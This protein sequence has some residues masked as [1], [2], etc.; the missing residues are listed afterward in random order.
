MELMIAPSGQALLKVHP[1]AEILCYLCFSRRKDNAEF[2]LAGSL[3]TIAAE[4]EAAVRNP[5]RKA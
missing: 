2:G 5:R 4:V 3:E 1:K